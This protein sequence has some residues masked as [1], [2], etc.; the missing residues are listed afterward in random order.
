MIKTIVHPPEPPRRRNVFEC[1][2]CGSRRLKKL[3][4]AEVYLAGEWPAPQVEVRR[5]HKC[6]VLSER[7]RW[8]ENHAALRGIA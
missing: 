8:I 1:P 6:G 4:Q 3:T 5:C 2:S 7:D